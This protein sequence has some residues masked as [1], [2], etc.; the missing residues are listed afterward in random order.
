MQNWSS[1]S[2]GVVFLQRRLPTSDMLS[3]KKGMASTRQC[4]GTSVIPGS[5]RI[6]SKVYKELLRNCQMSS[7]FI[8]ER[9]TICLDNTMPGSIWKLEAPLN[10]LPYFDAPRFHTSFC[11]GYG[12]QWSGYR[13]SVVT[14]HRWPWTSYSICKQDTNQMWAK[15]LCDKERTSGSCTFCEVFQTLPLR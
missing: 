13:G 5:M 14:K 3:L 8:W 12:C 9:E 2:K 4:Y 11:V 15:I 10:Q 1:K 6:L 7:H